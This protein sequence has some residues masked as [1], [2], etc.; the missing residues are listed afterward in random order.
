MILDSSWLLWF[1][2]QN[3][4]TNKQKKK[5]RKREMKTFLKRSFQFFLIIHIP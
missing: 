4:Q 5:K 3:K 1:S 2:S